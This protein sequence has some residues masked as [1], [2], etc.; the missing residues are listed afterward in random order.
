MRSQLQQDLVHHHP[1]LVPGNPTNAS[2]QPAPRNEPE[3]LMGSQVDCI[4][5][6]LEKELALKPTSYSHALFSYAFDATGEAV[7]ER[8]SVIWLAQP[9]TVTDDIAPLI[10]L[11]PDW[12]DPETNPPGPWEVN[13]ESCL[14]PTLE[15]TFNVSMEVPNTNFFRTCFSTC[16]S[17]CALG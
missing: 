11:E 7:E 4:L 14:P 9:L 2:T 16:V 17:T 12:S 13:F 15:T 6:F 10:D 5:N 8:R 3:E 1:T